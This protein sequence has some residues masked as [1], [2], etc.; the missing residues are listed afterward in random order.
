MYTVMYISVS[1]C[2]RSLNGPLTASLF[3]GMKK[4]NFPLSLT[5]I[6]FFTTTLSNIWLF[7][8]GRALSWL[9]FESLSVYVSNYSS[10]WCGIERHIAQSFWSQFYATLIIKL[11]KS[12]VVGASTC[13]AQAKKQKASE[14]LLKLFFA[15]TICFVCCWALYF[16]GGF[17]YK[18]ISLWNSFSTLFSCS[19]QQYFKSMYFDEREW[20]FLQGLQKNYLKHLLI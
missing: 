6:V 3:I 1:H 14:K 13:T 18:K 16:F 12:K 8:I 7:L 9:H 15:V 11:K 2:K 19:Y 20:K 10:K 4:W 5:Q 17:F